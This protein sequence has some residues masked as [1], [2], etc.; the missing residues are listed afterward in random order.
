VNQ[1]DKQLILIMLL[2]KKMDKKRLNVRYDLL[3]MLVLVLAT[4]VVYLQVKDYDF[5]SFDDNEYITE[6]RHVQ[7]GLTSGNVA[8][9]FTTF[10]LYLFMLST[11]KKCHGR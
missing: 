4:A 11:V 6:N 1:L 2:Q 7:T 10:I 8:W 9:A 5:I 3:V